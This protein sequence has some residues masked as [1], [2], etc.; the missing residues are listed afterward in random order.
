NVDFPDARM[1]VRGEHVH[2]VAHAGQHDVV[3]IAPRAGHEA[4]VLD[5]PHRLSDTEF[6]H[7]VSPEWIVGADDMAPTA[8]PQLEKADCYRP[9]S[10]LGR[11]S[12]TCG[13][14]VMKIVNRIMITRYGS[15]TLAI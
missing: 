6:R 7:C 2:A 14:S 5:A 4:L 12:A 13:T 9:A 11:N 10:R 3:D 1:R 15:V 8:A